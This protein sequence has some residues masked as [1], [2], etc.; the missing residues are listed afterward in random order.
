MCIPALAA[1][2]APQL[3]T[4]ALVI[5]GVTAVAKAGAAVK[6]AQAT[7]Q[8]AQA[9]LQSATDAYFIKVNQNNLRIRQE[10]R[11]ASQL[12]EDADIKSMKAQ[13][14]ALAAAAGAGV[15]GP[16]VDQLIMDFERSEGIYNDRVD[17]RIEDIQRQIE[18]TN[19]GY[20]SE[21]LSRINSIQPVSQ[22]EAIFGTIEPIA[23]FGLDYFD[24]KARYASLED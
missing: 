22:A 12:K 9:N 16:N 21:A 13:A 19:L 8:A 17:T 14:T 15:Q 2:T 4:A 7:N 1:L 3:A 10:N 5:S 24:T 6:K 11:Q 18:L 23:E 20:R